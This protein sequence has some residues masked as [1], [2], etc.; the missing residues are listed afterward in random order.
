[1]GDYCKPGDLPAGF[2]TTEEEN[3]VNEGLDKAEMD[4]DEGFL[5][6]PG[7]LLDVAICRFQE[8]S[9]K[10]E[11]YRMLL[12]TLPG[13]AKDPI[14]SKRSQILRFPRTALDEAGHLPESERS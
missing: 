10:V 13:K 2:L 5:P 9:S 3:I 4:P 11:P 14:Y 7:N 8:V 1:M 12:D 6:G